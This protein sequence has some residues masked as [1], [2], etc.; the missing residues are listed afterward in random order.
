[1]DVNNVKVIKEKTF[2]HTGVSRYFDTGVNDNDTHKISLE[3]ASKF[4]KQNDFIGDVIEVKK[5]EKPLSWKNK[6]INKNKK[7]K[8]PEIESALLK[9]HSRGEQ[10]EE[11][12]VKTN[13]FK[14]KLKKKEIYLNYATE[15]AA[16]TEILLTEQHGFIEPDEEERSADFRQ[17]EIARNVDITASSKHFKLNLDFGPYHHRYTK[18]GRH[19]LIGGR[20]GHV[21]AFDWITKKLHCEINV[22]EEVADVQWLHVETMF[23]CAQKKWTYFYDNKGT[24]IHCVKRLYN[25][26]KLEFLPYHFLLAAASTN[27]YLAWLDISIGEMVASFQTRL[28]DIRIMRQ[29]PNNGVLCVGGG[30]GVVSM[31]TPKCRVPVGKILCHGTPMTALAVDPKGNHMI[32]GGLDKQVKIWDIRKLEGP[33][34]IY[35]LRLPA[36]QIEV[37]QKSVLAFSMGNVCELYAN[38]LIENKTAPYLRHKVDDFIHDLRFCPFEDILG[39]STGKGFTS[40]LVPGSGEPNFDALEANPFQTKSQRKENEIHSLLDKIPA[41][42]ITLDPNEI[43]GVDVETL[44]SKVNAKK[45]VF[46]LK[47]PQIDFKSRRK[48]KGKG[49]SVKAARNKQ[50]V[51]DLKR[52]EFIQEIRKDKKEIIATHK[53]EINKENPDFIPLEQS[54]SINEFLLFYL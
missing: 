1:M 54:S 24:E 51:K 41:E 36:N 23:A 26:N 13:F 2:K 12:G 34:S 38:T 31:W 28:G 6:R 19:L 39:V 5:F 50:I 48:M 44:E 14:T 7:I 8:T 32:T 20:R 30:N 10:I 35:K 53:V 49:G 52:K 4:A 18:N 37:S 46:F 3:K 40:L 9:K 22:M 16:R 15:Q 21:A 11:S 45:S 17:I 42:F 27:G 47:A 29:N 43:A 33:L 25:I